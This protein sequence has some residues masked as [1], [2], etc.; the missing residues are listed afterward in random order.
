MGGG[1]EVQREQGVEDINWGS[2][3]QPYP[4]QIPH[5]TFSQLRPLCLLPFTALFTLLT[6]VHLLNIDKA[7]RGCKLI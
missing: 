2:N 1:T 3:P 4:R 6:A 7:R 5:W